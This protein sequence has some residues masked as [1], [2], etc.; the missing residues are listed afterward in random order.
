MERTREHWQIQ[1]GLT[2][3]DCERVDVICSEE[4][5]PIICGALVRYD[6]RQRC[7][8]IACVAKKGRGVSCNDFDYL[9]CDCM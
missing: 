2:N 3:Y 1:Y 8:P 4:E 9:Y 5:L 6:E 7:R